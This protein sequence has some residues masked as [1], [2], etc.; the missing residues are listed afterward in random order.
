METTETADNIANMAL[1]KIGD[2]YGTRKIW[3]F[4]DDDD[5]YKISR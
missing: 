5:D 4:D 1:E 3:Y 2:L